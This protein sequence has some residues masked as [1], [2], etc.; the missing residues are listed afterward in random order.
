MRVNVVFTSDFTCPWCFIGHV[1]LAEAIGRMPPP[2]T[3]TINRSSS[4][5]ACLLRAWTA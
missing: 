4:T 5:P 2:W 3:S 1:Q